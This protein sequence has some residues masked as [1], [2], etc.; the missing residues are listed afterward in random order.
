MAR[1]MG[2]HAND[3]RDFAQ[4]AGCPTCRAADGAKNV[5]T[6]AGALA[7]IARKGAPQD[8]AMAAA[9]C[10]PIRVTAAGD[11]LTGCSAGMPNGGQL[12][13]EHSRSLMR[14]PPAWD[15]CGVTAMP[16]TRKPRPRS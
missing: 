15:D 5:R 1:A 10:G 12:N 16:S 6:A 9:I 2:S 14:L 3:L 7:E 13:P 4:M 11:V 8:L